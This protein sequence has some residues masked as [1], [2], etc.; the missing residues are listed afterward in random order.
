MF[1]SNMNTDFSTFEAKFAF[2]L[3]KRQ[4][5]CFGIGGILGGGLYYLTKDYIGTDMASFLMSAVSLPFFAFGLYKKDGLTL[6]KIIWNYIKEQYFRNKERVV[7]KE[8]KKEKNGAREKMYQT[9]ASF[10]GMEDAHI[11]I[12]VAESL[13]LEH[14]NESGIC[15]HGNNEY[16]IMFSFSDMNYIQLNDEDQKELWSLWCMFLNTFDPMARYQFVFHNH[17]AN[18]REI[19]EKVR[20]PR[21]GDEELDVYVK[22][23]NQ[24]Q[25]A[26]IKEGNK[27]LDK[28]MYIIIRFSLARNKVK[29]KAM[30]YAERLISDLYDKMGVEAKMLSG[31][32]YLHVLYKM[33]NPG[34]DEF[35]FQYD[36]LESDEGLEKEAIAR[37]KLCFGDHKNTFTIGEKVGCVR[38]LSVVANQLS[39]RFLCKSLDLDCEMHM[40]VHV[41]PISRSKAIKMYRRLVSDLQKNVIDEQKKANDSGYGMN[42]IS[43]PLKIS[44]EAAQQTL[45]GIMKNDEKLFLTTITM[46]YVADNMEIL[47]RNVNMAKSIANEESC[48]LIDLTYQQEDAF[49]SALPL[50]MNRLTTKREMTTTSLGLFLPYK[51]KELLQYG[52][53]VCVG[54]NKITQK[55]IMA[56]VTTLANPNTI[57]TGTPGRGKSFFI[58]MMILF[59]RLKTSFDIIICDVECEYAK[60]TQTLGGVN[61]RLSQRGKV[62]KNI[63]DINPDCDFNESD[64]VSDK[65][66]LMMSI[67]EQILREENGDP[68]DKSIID[69][70]TRAIYKPFLKSRDEKDIPILGDFYEELRKQEGERSAYLADALEVYVKGSLNYFN[71]RTNIDTSNRMI[72]Y[73]INDLSDQLRPIAMLIVQES[74]WERISSNRDKKKFTVFVTDEAHVFLKYKQTAMYVVNNF[75]RFRKWGGIPIFITQN[76]TDILNSSQAQNVFYNSD[77]YILLGQASGDAERLRDALGLSNEQYKCILTR[78]KGEGLFIFGDTILPF[79]NRIDQELKTYQLA[80]TKVTDTGG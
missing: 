31:R 24:I 71:H 13:P 26:Y 48:D 68:I 15:E 60:M 23:L 70:C 63:F 19:Y 28:D 8:E 2:G 30:E 67:F 43:A 36:D 18:A 4:C 52:N 62:Y 72:N 35:T 79:V 22:E 56:D 49:F 73:I 29:A 78:N 1:Y 20:I 46:V 38:Q 66:Q 45:E 59:Y 61:I 25:K 69:R 40:S 55:I 58:K 3:T 7:N 37:T 12:T 77:C 53:S 11:P 42:N 5:I 65:S 9:L 47:E 27:G 54:V 74:V 41:E 6:E 64:P 17:F 34:S 75:K 50:G 76:V 32:E 39:D 10:F 14:M 44:L 51:I 80:T 21:I 57:V 33:L 16:S